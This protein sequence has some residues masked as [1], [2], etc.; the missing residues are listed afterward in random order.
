[1]TGPATLG[2]DFGTSNSAAGIAVDGRPLLIELEPGEQTLPTA[3]FFEEDG[4]GMDIGRRATQALIEG[5]EGRFMRS[6]K[7]VLGT[8]LMHEERR[9]QGRRMTFVHIIAGFLAELKTRAEVA[10]GQEYTRALSGRPVRFHTGDDARNARAEEDLR[11]CYLAAGFD[12]VR[13]MYEPEAALRATPPAPGTGLIVDIGGGTSDFTAFEQGASGDAMILASHG[14]RIGGT[15]FDRR[16]SIDHVMPELGRGSAIR[17]TMGNETLP[18]PARIFN[19]L[20][21]WAM[22]PFLYTADTRR[23]ARELAHQAVE[24]QKLKRLVTV[25]EE[26]LGHDLAFAVE[27]GKIAVN[28][29]ES[30]RI[31]L[32]MVERGL[33]VPLSPEAMQNDLSEAMRGIAEAAAETL[34]LAQIAPGAVDRIVLVGGSS[35]MHAV[36]D[37]VAQV[38]P[39]ARV[40]SGKALTGVADGLALSA[41]IAFA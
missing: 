15:D 5:D 23:M 29:G 14:V 6:L 35:L 13:F 17:N 28:A 3:V 40:D 12:E 18:A 1:M 16:I 31:L 10:T 24:P 22:I 7:S 19:D 30:T 39:N 4:T 27:R 33:S 37:A 36:Q 9:I 38:C 11:A 8:A 34:R 26:E 21:T 20:A 32:D 41:D 2:I 25:L